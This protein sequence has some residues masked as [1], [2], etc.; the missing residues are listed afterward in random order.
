MEPWFDE[1]E[2][3]AVFDYMN[4][5][6]WVTEFERTKEFEQE[7]A[8]FCGA[9]HCFATNN[10]TVAIAL[11]LMAV[12]VGPGDE[13]IVPD[14]TMIATPNAAKILGAVPVFVDVERPNLCIDR[15]LV[16]RAITKRTKAVVHVS[17]NGRSNDL[18]G[19]KALCEAHR[20]PLIEDAAQ[21]F[22][23]YFGTRHLGTIGDL[24]T[25]SF[26]PPKIISTGQGGAVITNDDNLANR[27]KRLKDFGRSNGGIDVHGTIGYNFKFTDIQAVIGIEQMKKLEFRIHRKKAIYDRYVQRLST[28]GAV[29]LLPTDLKQVTPWFID[30]YVDNPEDIIAWLR[31]HKIGSRKMYPPVHSQEAYRLAGRFPVTESFSHRGLWLPSSSKLSDHEIDEVC[32]VVAHYYERR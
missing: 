30:V 1:R 22:G 24:G 32:D 20:L 21:S 7:I 18:D 9:K 27:I 5:G 26:S 13:V 25:F 16:E 11:A 29:E 4:S 12:D 31:Q 17:F 10:G 19:L 2:A 3:Q 14:L 28:I 15:D 8:R 23:S 6:G